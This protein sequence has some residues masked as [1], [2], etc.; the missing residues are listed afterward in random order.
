ML[1]CRL[2]LC[3]VLV[4]MSVGK[5]SAQA[6]WPSSLRKLHIVKCLLVVTACIH[7]HDIAGFEGA[8]GG[9]SKHHPGSP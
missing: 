3:T 8:L 6:G 5:P 7:T 2:S 4:I 9:E 1:A